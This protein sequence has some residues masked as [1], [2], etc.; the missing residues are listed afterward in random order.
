MK[1]KCK[2]LIVDDEKDFRE[3]LGRYFKT[4]NFHVI[5][6]ANAKEAL[7]II[8]Q[9]KPNIIISDVDMPGINGFEFLKT[10][11]ANPRY[12]DIPFILMSG[13]KI[14][15][16]DIIE[17]YNYGSDDYIIKPF[18]FEV[19]LAKVKAILKNRKI[20]LDKS[21]IKIS[22]TIEIDQDSKEVR[23]NGK[24]VKLTRKEFELLVFFAKNKKRVFSPAE[25]L[26]T[27][28]GFNSDTLDPHTVETHVSNI[29]KKLPAL[30]KKLV[31]VPGYG[32]KLDL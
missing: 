30:S 5:L 14:N 8:S 10:I 9:S 22:S 19:L 15:Q 20:C 27:V 13:K 12:S 4:N 18:S 31:N 7:K 23:L 6:S 16:I 3:L 2:I 17:G 26:E 1:G 29:R 21:T 25:I 11:R 24:K 32:Y 28:W